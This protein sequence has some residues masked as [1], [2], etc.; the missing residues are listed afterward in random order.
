MVEGQHAQAAIPIRKL[1][2]ENGIDGGGQDLALGVHGRPLGCPV[3]PRCTL[4]GHRHRERR[5]GAP[6]ATFGIDVPKRPPIDVGRDD[7][8]GSTDL[9]E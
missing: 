4:R 9:W 7:L 2:G 8:D 3:L 6:G 1:V 5:P